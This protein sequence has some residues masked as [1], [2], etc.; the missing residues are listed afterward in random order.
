MN[1]RLRELEIYGFKS[2]GE[3]AF[4]VFPS[5]LNIVLGPNGSGKSNVVDSIRWVLGDQSFRNLRISEAE[6]LLFVGQKPFNL[7]W[8]RIMI[9]SESNPSREAETYEIQRKIY[10]NGEA[11]YLLNNEP[12]RLKDIQKFLAENQIGTR[13][14]TIVNQ[15]SADLFIKASPEERYIMLSEILGIKALEI[16]K[17]ETK[18]NLE[19]IKERLKIAK[20]KLNSLEPQVEV[21]L[22]EKQKRDRKEEIEKQ[23]DKFFIEIRSRKKFLLKERLK[24]LK[25]EI[26]KIQKQKEEKEKELEA[27]SKNLEEGSMQ[28]RLVELRRKENELL[29]K[30]NEILE[31]GFMEKTYQP[32][33]KKQNILSFIQEKLNF[34]ITLDGVKEIKE[35]IR[36]ILNNINLSEKTEPKTKTT[37]EIQS[38]I[39]KIDHSLSELKSQINKEEKTEQ[40]LRNKMQETLLRF[41]EIQNKSFEMRHIEERLTEEFKSVELVLEELKNIKE[42]KSTQ[43]ELGILM[44]EEEQFKSELHRIGEI[45]EGIIYKG[46]KILKNLE[47]LRK[48]NTDLEESY[49][50]LRN[51]FTEYD[52][53]IKSTFSE[54]IKKI[55]QS[56][57]E[58]FYKLYGGVAKLILKEENKVHVFIDHPQKK[59]KILEAL[60]GGEKALFSI[61]LIF[62]LI[63]ISE[64][65]F[66]VLD[67]ID[68]ALDEQNSY[69][70]AEFLKE[71]SKKTQFIIVSHNRSTIESADVL[72]GVS[73]RNG[74]SKVFSL[75]LKEALETIEQ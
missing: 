2:F 31:K 64:P 17:N 26:V 9:E 32:L 16:K 6:D 61:S 75:K 14:F 57:I 50:K 69:K 67:E 48:E 15:G 18:K 13:G 74:I 37:S 47:I 52:E 38:E 60:S 33:Q 39:E 54:G 20:M 25:T 4:L 58:Y 3:K 29:K 71:L 43:E 41:K 35:L 19:Q 1:L 28:E 62:A 55:N 5:N 65:P 34:A 44:R 66:L 72:L 68:A 56:L 23:L 30:R 36:E 8:I 49:F 7:A 27:F 10:R 24:T 63:K 42:K 12:A 46:E 53:K 22:N 21:F 70:F 45:N 73:L 51:L 40:K 59:V 11:E